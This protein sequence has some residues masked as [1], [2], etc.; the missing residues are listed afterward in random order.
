[1]PDTAIPLSPPR[2]VVKTDTKL[3]KE[4]SPVLK[5]N[6]DSAPPSP[7]EQ[8][9]F[10]LPDVET[11][12]VKPAEKENETRHLPKYEVAGLKALVQWLHDLPPNKKYIP[13]D[14]PDPIGLLRDVR[15]IISLIAMTYF[16]TI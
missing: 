7:A 4:K 8:I 13:K 14:I 1:M 11:N 12:D 10:C 6:D 9:T 3:F 2:V 16:V 15:V 5:E